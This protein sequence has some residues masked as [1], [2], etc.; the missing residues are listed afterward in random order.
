M[1]NQT[2]AFWYTARYLGVVPVYLESLQVEGPRMA[3]RHWS[4]IPLRAAVEFVWG[5]YTTMKT[6][7]NSD[8]EPSFPLVI[9]GELSVPVHLSVAGTEE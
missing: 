3:E 8:Y 4:L 6:L 9:T 2:C 1:S 5:M 7:V